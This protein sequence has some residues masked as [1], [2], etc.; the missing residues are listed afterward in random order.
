MRRIWE[1]GHRTQDTCVNPYI[2]VRF[3]PYGPALAFAEDE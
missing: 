1:F 3:A 2:L